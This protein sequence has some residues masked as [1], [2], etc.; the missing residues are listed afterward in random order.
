MIQLDLWS[1]SRTKNPTPTPSVVR[2]PTPP[3]NL[4]LL[5]TP[6]PIPQPKFL[7]LLNDL[8]HSANS[9]ASV[10]AQST[11]FFFRKN[12]DK[13]LFAMQMSNLCSCSR[14]ANTVRL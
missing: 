2:N 10:A 1:R 9:T 7:L 3:K 12:T 14:F 13:L 8:T 5:A 4:R 11:H 6:T